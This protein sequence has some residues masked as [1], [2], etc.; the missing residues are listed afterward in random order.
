[1]SQSAVTFCAQIYKIT[2]N[3]DGGGRLTL[4]FGIDALAAMQNL[5]AVQAHGD[6][7]LAI[8]IAPY[9]GPDS[10]VVLE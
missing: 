7:N 8:A 6:M 4:E 5:L 2:M 3:K 1:M 10:N 9:S